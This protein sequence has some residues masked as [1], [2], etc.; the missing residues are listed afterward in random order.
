MRLAISP[1]QRWPIIIVT[2]LVLQMVF[3]V[4]MA[5]IA[6][7]DPHHAV[8]PDYYNR[9]VNWDSAMAQSRRDRALGWKSTAEMTRSSGGAAVLQ[10]ALVDSLG[11]AVAV[12][13]VSAEALAVSHAGRINRVALSP[14]SDSYVGAIA[15]AAPG[16]WD[17]QLRAVRGADVFTAKLRTEL[18]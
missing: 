11:A 15:E 16:L 6:G 5:R 10:I 12:D 13:S 17:V 7:S 9:A 8:E 1:S 3:G 14:R 2:V 18:R 4:W